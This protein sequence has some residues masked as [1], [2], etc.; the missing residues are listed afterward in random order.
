MSA[1]H[2][3]TFF[4]N[5]P[6]LT[7]PLL[8]NRQKL[9][10]TETDSV[11]PKGKIVYLAQK[12]KPAG[13]PRD[14]ILLTGG[15]GFV[16]T[17][18][19]GEIMRQNP[20]VHVFAVVR[21]GKKWR[22]A[23]REF[24]QSVLG[25]ELGEEDPA[26]FNPVYGHELPKGWSARCTAL[27]G[28][29]AAGD[30][31]NGI[32]L[33]NLSPED[34]ETV[35]RR[36]FAVIHLACCTSYVTSYAEKRKWAVAFNTL[37]G[38]CTDNDMSIH[39]LGGT[40]RTMYNDVKT[41]ADINEESLFSNG[42]F[43]LKHVQH[44]ILNRYIDA[45]LQGTAYDVP[46]IFGA[47]ET[48]GQFPGLHYEPLRIIAIFAATGLRL[49]MP[50][51]TV[52]VDVL[53]NLMVRNALHG[54][55]SNYFRVFDQTHVNEAIMDAELVRRGYK[56]ELYPKEEFLRLALARGMPAK[57]LNRYF[58]PTCVEDATKIVEGARPRLFPAGMRTMPS[59]EVLTMSLD[60]I[61]TEW[62]G[63]VARYKKK[64]QRSRL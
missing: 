1:P 34:L 24:P 42:Y 58:T 8:L 29:C 47:P 39:Y 46:Y 50:W 45:G 3:P 11:E 32:S 37:C 5:D 35:A 10:R 52:T 2:D 33:F 61:S 20:D 30:P 25:S 4:L 36:C 31:N 15:T 21:G 9:Q 17:Y 40:G 19:L 53:C 14:A 54:E 18:M 22:L 55:R 44:K 43:R 12:H 16:G 48:G 26:D 41:E 13:P 49:D 51:D 38:F 57:T 23:S 7:Q 56:T 27:D 60:N 59:A 62:E 6:L 63:C 28:D 64:M